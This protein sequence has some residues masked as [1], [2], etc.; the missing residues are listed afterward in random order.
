VELAA[1]AE[2]AVVAAAD[3]RPATKEVLP[4]CSEKRLA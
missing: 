2:L 4:C 3:V 1:R